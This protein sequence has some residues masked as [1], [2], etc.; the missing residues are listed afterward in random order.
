MPHPIHASYAFATWN[1]YWSSKESKRIK[2]FQTHKLIMKDTQVIMGRQGSNQDGRETWEKILG[3]IRFHCIKDSICSLIFLSSEEFC[4]SP[5]AQT[6]VSRIREVLLGYHDN[7]IPDFIFM[8]HQP[9]SPVWMPSEVSDIKMNMYSRPKN[10]GNLKG[11]K[12][13]KEYSDL[14]FT[15][16][17]CDSHTLA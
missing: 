3:E 7:A 1:Q 4:E 11:S 6:G 15:L 10:D 16:K 14:I 5:R 13:S 12:V 17:T 9:I 8:P 2:L